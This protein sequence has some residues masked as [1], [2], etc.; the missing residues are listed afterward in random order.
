MDFQSTGATAQNS[1]QSLADLDASLLEASQLGLMDTAQKLLARGASVNARVKASQNTPLMLASYHARNDFI[2]MLIR[3]GAD[4][5][6]SNASGRD[7]LWYAITAGKVKTVR[8]L[9]EA[10]ANVNTVYRQ[11]GSPLRMAVVANRPDIVSLLI[12]AGAAINTPDAEGST[13]LDKAAS[14]GFVAIAS[15]LLHAQADMES[16]NCNGRTPL[17]EALY[18]ARAN[19]TVQ[20][21][22]MTVARLLLEHGANANAAATDGQTAL[23]T[24]VSKGDGA[25]V[26]CLLAAGAEINRKNSHGYTA[27][28]IAAQNGK[29]DAVKLLLERGADTAAINSFGQTAGMLAQTAGHAVISQTL[30]QQQASKRSLIGIAAHFLKPLIRRGVAQED[31]QRENDQFTAL[32]NALLEAVKAGE[33]NVD[34]LLRNGASVSAIDAS[35]QTALLY[36]TS[37]SREALVK[38]LITAGAD[39]NASDNNGRT[40]LMNVCFIANTKQHDYC[41]KI[42]RNLL[43]AGARVNVANTAG[44]TALMNAANKGNE[45][46]VRLLLE[47]GANPFAVAK[48]KAKKNALSLAQEN[49]HESIAQLIREEMDAAKHVTRLHNMSKTGSPTD[50][51]QIQEAADTRQKNARP[52]APHGEPQQFASD[53]EPCTVQK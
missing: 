5:N 39:V 17:L 45:E 37:R 33:N 29:E 32:G 6:A 19:E 3:Y 22:H 21:E 23:M 8:L 52:S 24:A 34:S 15:L 30:Q 26:Q 14:N 31:A 2:R 16:K 51:K 42:A 36:A 28:M 48:G 11:T 53:N 9:L 4:V 44:F 13:A 50:A 7:A 40:A 38:K 25:I 35:G 12:D 18:A 20:S 43:K 46:I 49:G 41:I 47:Y 1:G 10:G 27:L